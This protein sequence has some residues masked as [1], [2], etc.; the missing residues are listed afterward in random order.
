M[1]SADI[2][3]DI[4]RKAK[5]KEEALEVYIVFMTRVFPDESENYA[6]VWAERFRND[7]DKTDEKT[8]KA[9]LKM[10]GLGS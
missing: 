5:L 6:E 8:K 9:L 2:L 4:G 3:T 10:A 1:I 7:W